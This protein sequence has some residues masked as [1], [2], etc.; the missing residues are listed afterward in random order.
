MEIKATENQELLGGEQTRPTR[1]QAVLEAGGQQLEATRGGQLT[2]VA[3]SVGL[4]G[5]RDGGR[6]LGCQGLGHLRGVG[7]MTGIHRRCPWRT[8]QRRGS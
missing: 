7:V 6:D 8:G 2:C 1:V 4:R 5:R 3:R